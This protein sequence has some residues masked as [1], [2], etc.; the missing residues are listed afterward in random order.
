MRSCGNAFSFKL[1]TATYDGKTQFSFHGSG[2]HANAPR[3]RTLPMLLVLHSRDYSDV[4]FL[5]VTPCSLASVYQYY[6]RSACIHLLTL[7]DVTLE[8]LQSYTVKQ[9]IFFLHSVM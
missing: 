4:I 2:G 5:V 9:R 6:G 7:R 3:I 8:L 1:L